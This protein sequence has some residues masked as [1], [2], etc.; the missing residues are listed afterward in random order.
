MTYKIYVHQNKSN[1]KIYVGFTKNNYKRW[2]DTKS[3]AFNS[4]SKEY[5]SPLSRAIRRDGWDGFTHD[6]WEE[7]DNKEDALE[8]EKFWIEFFRSNRKVYGPDYGYNLHEGG[9]VPPSA[10]PGHCKGIKRSEETKLKMSKSH[11]GRVYPTGH[12][13]SD[14]TKQ[15]MSESAIN[16]PKSEEAK[17][18]MSKAK[19]GKN[20]PNF[21]KTWKT[22]NGKRV[23]L[24]KEKL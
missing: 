6:I 2:K 17:K 9:N 23:Y 16:K 22:I 1:L 18:N 11:I 13:V 12:I 24:N 3:N 21:G 4:K 14:A 7:W 8:A 5:D 19:S 20:H 10:K 15:K